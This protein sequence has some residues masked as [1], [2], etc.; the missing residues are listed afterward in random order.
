MRKTITFLLL[1]TT[2][3]A[4]AAFNPDAPFYTDKPDQKAIALGLGNTTGY[5]AV[6]Y[7]CP[8]GSNA[9]AGT[10]PDAPK[11]TLWANVDGTGGFSGFTTRAAGTAI[12][13][14]RGGVWRDDTAVTLA[15][16][17][18]TKTSPITFRD[19]QKPG[20]S[21]RPPEI[22]GYFSSV[23]LEAIFKFS[24]SGSGVSDEGYVIENLILTSAKHGDGIGIY[25]Y[26]DADYITVRNCKLSGFSHAVMPNGVNGTQNR[27]VLTNYDD[28]TFTHDANGPDTLTSTGGWPAGILKGDGIVIANAAN[29]GNNKTFRVESVAGNI[30]SFTDS[31]SW[32]VV[33]E[34]GTTGV[35]VTINKSDGKNSGIV[36][37]RNLIV[38]NRNGTFGHYGPL[39][40]I[41]NNVLEGNGYISSIH[42]HHLYLSDSEDVIVQ[43]NKMLD[44][45]PYGLGPNAGKCMTVAFVMHGI[46]SNIN[47][48]DN[49]IT[50]S[51]STSGGGCYGISF[52]GAYTVENGGSEHLQNSLIDGNYIANMGSQ[53]ISCE[54]CDTVTISNNVIDC[55][56]TA[57]CA[58]IVI[59]GEGREAED[60]LTKDI[61]I[62]NNTVI[63][64][65]SSLL[66]NISVFG[67]SASNAVADTTG[68]FTISNNTVDGWYKCIGVGA[69]G[70]AT[71]TVT[72]NTTTNCGAGGGEQP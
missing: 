27:V 62:S 12:A 47:I 43:N 11:Q 18:S 4:N 46:M 1:L 38:N 60:G 57:S 58:G 52:T 63:A 65:N 55:S 8:D 28:L 50:Q 39:S 56:K 32:D 13:L 42:D 5:N 31:P 40:E 54:G 26:N 36:M 49:Y 33:D 15:N 17:N 3:S 23:A 67:I 24:A 7:V 21:T 59:P 14:C 22:I 25:I 64:R 16:A 6:I 2:L 71:I 41:S 72:G 35:S 34:T 45:G 51:P 44:V 66:T 48:L 20:G 61:T 19:Y 70:G 68:T 69:S 29:A 53:A 37:T 10:S 9:N 30:I